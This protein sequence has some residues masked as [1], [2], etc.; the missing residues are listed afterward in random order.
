MP[1]SKLTQD[2]LDNLEKPTIEDNLLDRLQKSLDDVTTETSFNPNLQY[3]RKLKDKCH[4]PI[5]CS[6]Y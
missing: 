1:I 6:K 2:F 3:S 5:K 4:N